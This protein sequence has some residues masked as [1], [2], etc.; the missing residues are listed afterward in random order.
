MFLHIFKDYITAIPSKLQRME[1]RI[2]NLRRLYRIKGIKCETALKCLC[3]KGVMI[4]KAAT[5]FMLWSHASK[6]PYKELNAIY[7]FVIIIHE[8]QSTTKIY[9]CIRSS[10]EKRQLK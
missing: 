5:W 7:I 6:R 4:L 1:I 8:E 10:L 2:G 9:D 3:D